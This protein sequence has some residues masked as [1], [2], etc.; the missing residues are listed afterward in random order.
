MI[1]FFMLS[2]AAAAVNAINL[3]QD[4]KKLNNQA[5]GMPSCGSAMIT[6]PLAMPQQQMPQQVMLVAQP[7]STCPMA[8]GAKDQGLSQCDEPDE[9]SEVDGEVDADAETDADADGEAEIEVDA[10]ID[11]EGSPM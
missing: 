4:E 10:E 1:R 7:V 3:Y 6:V 9:L 8:C 5:C 11:A 2:V